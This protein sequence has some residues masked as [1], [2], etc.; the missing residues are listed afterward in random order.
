MSLHLL[1]PM[2][3]GVGRG[4][5]KTVRKKCALQ[6]SEEDERRG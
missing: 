1:R 2:I 3:K 4:R 5:K 6:K